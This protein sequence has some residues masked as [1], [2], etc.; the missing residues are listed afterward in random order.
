MPVS[1]P[2]L[3]QPVLDRH[4]VECHATSRANGVKELSGTV[5]DPRGWSAGFVNLWRHA[6]AWNGGNGICRQEGPRSP[7]GQ[8]G[9]RKAQLLPLLEHDHHGVR[10]PPGDLE[11]LVL[12]LD[13]NSNFFGAYH[14]LAAQARGALVVPEIR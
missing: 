10:L 1:F 8:V 6:W 2:R 9:A 5:T 3:V 7:A 12:W 14:D 4:C 13:T 11:R